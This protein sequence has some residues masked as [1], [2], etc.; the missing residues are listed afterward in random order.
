MQI[1]IPGHITGILGF[2]AFGWTVKFQTHIAGPEIAL[3]V[4]GFGVSTAFNITNGLLIDLHRDK[5]AAAT[6]AVNFARCMMSAGGS[7][8]IIPMCNAM[9]KLRCQRVLRDVL[10][11]WCRSWMGL[12]VPGADLCGIDWCCVAGHAGWDEVEVGARGEET[13]EKG[14]GRGGESVDGICVVWDGTEIEDFDP[15]GRSS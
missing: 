13:D 10:I 7:A 6:A 15:H 8:A 3:F 1:V 12:H 14:E 4:I 11:G 9:S 2:L 5:P